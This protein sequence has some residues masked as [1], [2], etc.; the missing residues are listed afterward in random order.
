MKAEHRLDSFNGPIL[1]SIGVAWLVFAGDHDPDGISV[2]TDKTKFPNTG[3]C[4]DILLGEPVSVDWL[5]VVGGV[6]N[7]LCSSS[8]LCS[9]RPRTCAQRMFWDVN[10]ASSIAEISLQDVTMGGRLGRRIP[11]YGYWPRCFHLCRDSVECLD[12]VEFFSVV[13]AP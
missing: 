11:G 2:N 3:K 4:G 1:T 7:E 6:L 9:D 10:M 8:E 12:E 13:L 5:V